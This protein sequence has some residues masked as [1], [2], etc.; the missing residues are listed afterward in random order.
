MVRHLLRDFNLAAVP[1]VFGYAGC[2]E[3]VIADLRQ[4]SGLYRTVALYGRRPKIAD[5][6]DVYQ[7]ND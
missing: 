3:G 4:D 2:A 5:T 1:R 6:N 7:F